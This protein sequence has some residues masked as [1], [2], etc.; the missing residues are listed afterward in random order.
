M[1]LLIP[2]SQKQR[3]G[4]KNHSVYRFNNKHALAPGLP[5][6]LKASLTGEGAVVSPSASF[7]LRLEI[8]TKD[9]SSYQPSY[10][11]EV[12][13]SLSVCKAA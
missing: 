5:L 10:G 11:L 12:N 8:V 2:I 9:V 4:E 7:S 13:L 1:L 3:F 6:C